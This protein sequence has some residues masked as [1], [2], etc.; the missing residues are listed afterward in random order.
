MRGVTAELLARGHKVSVFEPADSWSRSNLVREHGLGAI[1]AFHAAFRALKSTYY[2]LASFDIEQ[3]LAGVD[4]VLVHEWNDLKLVA[5]AGQFRRRNAGVR[6]FFHDTHHRAVTA[7]EELSRFDLS[8]YD[9]VLAY[10]ASLKE[11]YLRHGWGRQVHVWQEAADTRTFFPR[12]ADGDKAGVVWIG[13]WGDEERTE[14]L[15]EYVLGPISRARLTATA[16]GVRYPAYALQELS[17]AGI[18]F[19]G[20]LPNF[21]AP[22]VFAGF[23]ATVHVPRRPYARDLPGIPTIRPFEALACGI[24]LISAPWRDSE[25][26]FR[27]GRD[28]LMAHDG[29]EMERHLK[30]VLLEPSLAATLRANGLETIRTRH[31]CAHRVDELLKIYGH[32]QRQSACRN[33]AALAGVSP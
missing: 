14:E 31:T 13:N 8:E 27:I 25:S 5:A 12:A 10:G 24:P 3:A 26:L 11:A 17:A 28:F 29:N 18:Q 7:H 2:D 6:L 16:Y 21:K 33:E 4:L 32:T 20:W 23:K 19:A 15:R 9:G 30:T 22:E 1:E